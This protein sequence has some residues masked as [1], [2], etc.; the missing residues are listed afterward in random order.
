MNRLAINVLPSIDPLVHPPKR[1]GRFDDKD[2]SEP[3]EFPRDP[4]TGHAPV[5][6]CS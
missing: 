5:K 3:K 4:K 1:L 6:R 2:F